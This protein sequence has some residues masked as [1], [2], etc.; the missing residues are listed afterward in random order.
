MQLAFLEISY[1]APR[2][3]FKLLR[4]RL[5]NKLSADIFWLTA[6]KRDKTLAENITKATCQPSTHIG[7]LREQTRLPIDWN[8][9]DRAF[10]GAF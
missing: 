8:T 3:V 7:Q 5:F 9:T 1:L 4:R 10:N 2:C 6:K